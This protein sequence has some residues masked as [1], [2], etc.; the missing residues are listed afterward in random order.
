MK[1]NK[2]MVTMMVSGLCV[3]TLGDEGSAQPAQGSQVS[4]AETGVAVVSP[5]T[6]PPI[7]DRG[8]R[9]N[10]RSLPRGATNH[11]ALAPA[12][13]FAIFI[14]TRI[15]TPLLLLHAGEVPPSG[16]PPLFLT[17]DPLL[18][19]GLQLYLKTRTKTVR[20]AVAEQD[21][22]VI[23]ICPK[24]PMP[25]SFQGMLPPVSDGGLTLRIS[26]QVRVMTLQDQAQKGS[27][28]GPA[29]L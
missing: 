29:K 13:P 20:I 11:K 18:A 6:V 25:D 15:E 26:D 3:L 28:A 23:I 16:S 2:T 4:G 12:E 17:I 1:M 21:E 27:Q 10:H 14:G 24:A 22:G 9:G 8:G 19:P 5:T 7:V